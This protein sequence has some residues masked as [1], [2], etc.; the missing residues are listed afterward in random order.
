MPQ[1]LNCIS[2]CNLD[3]SEMLA[4]VQPT[5]LLQA[6]LDGSAPEPFYNNGSP[7]QD[8]VP[9]YSS[10]PE[11]PLLGVPIK[12]G[13]LFHLT[14]H[15]CFEPVHFALY[16]NGFSFT[17]ID[18]VESSVSVSP[19][20]LVRNCRF[21]SGECA[22][23]KSFKVSLVGFEPAWYFAVQSTGEREAEEE[24][25]DWVL[26]LSHA[27]LLVTDSLLPRFSHVC[28]PVP[29]L[30]QTQLRLIAG[31]LIHRDNS[32]SVSVLFCELHAQR[33][34]CARLVLY[35]NER[36]EISVTEIAINESS[37]CSDIVGINSSCFVVDTHHF[38]SPTSSE[39]KL[40]LRAISNIK[41]KIRNREL[42]PSEKDLTCYRD[43]IREHLMQL[44][45]TK[46]PQ[47]SPI[48]LLA[49]RPD[50]KAARLAA[51]AGIRPVSL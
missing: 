10:E 37:V 13:V 47:I 12:E 11:Q 9:T 33:M 44:E 22:K 1:D 42:E 23:L 41:V 24:R 29:G 18:G 3:E 48:A 35:E 17:A 5:R 14:A 32:G 15:D 19:F 7:M 36:C 40:W 39:R 16:V 25:S 49:L 20:A 6:E 2:T 30:L 21:Q 38:A 43:S 46:E 26:G 27:I 8:G 51:G 50:P 34:Q 31:Y 4:E 45:A 28:D